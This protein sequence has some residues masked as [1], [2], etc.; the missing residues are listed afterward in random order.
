MYLLG[1]GRLGEGHVSRGPA[2]YLDHAQ[3]V[4]EEIKPHV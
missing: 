3:W 1:M 2:A 4:I